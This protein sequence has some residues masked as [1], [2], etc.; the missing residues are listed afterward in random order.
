M[1]AKTKG[2]AMRTFAIIA[3]WLIVFG[4][5]STASADS[6][7]DLNKVYQETKNNISVLLD[8]REEAELRAEGMA[9]NA[10]WLPSSL[11]NEGTKPWEDFLKK[12]PKNKTIYIYCRSGGRAGRVLSRLQKVGFQEVVNIGGLKDWK[13]KNLPTTEFKGDGQD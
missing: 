2:F 4:L 1:E 3:H 7:V 11:A 13:A 6:E 10:Q 9:V 8:V 12:T 5:V